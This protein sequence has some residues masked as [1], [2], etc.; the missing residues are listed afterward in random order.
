MSRKSGYGK[1]P[2]YTSFGIS[3]FGLSNDQN[4]R[5]WKRCSCVS[6]HISFYVECSSPD[7]IIT[8]CKLHCSS[9]VGYIH[10]M[11]WPS[12]EHCLWPRL[13]FWMWLLCRAV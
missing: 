10:S 3:T 5:G 2:G 13:K 4:D 12:R 1:H 7:N 8:D 9:F 6:N 11:L